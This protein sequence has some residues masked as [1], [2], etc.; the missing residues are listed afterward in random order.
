M[1][2]R[3]KGCNTLFVA[4]HLVRFVGISPRSVSY[5]GL[6]DRQAVTEQWFCLH[7][8]GKDDPDFSQFSLAGCEI[9]LVK[10]HRNVNYVLV[11]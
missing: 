9:L 2:L 5:A 3:K 4:D 6:K 1:Y 8:P 11:H 7:L 10:R